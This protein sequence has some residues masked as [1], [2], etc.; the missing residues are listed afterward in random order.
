M[1]AAVVHPFREEGEYRGA[2]HIGDKVAS[3]FYIKA[4]KNSPVAQVDIDLAALSA[5][6]SKSGDC[7]CQGTGDPG[8]HFVVNP[9]GY[10]VFHVSGGAG[11][12][13]VHLRK[14]DEDPKLPI[15]DSRKL[16]EGDIYSG[17]IL[18]PGRYSVTNTL[19]ECTA[20][21]RVPYLVPGKTAYRPP[22]PVRVD[23]AEKGFQPGKI[24]AHPGQGILFHFRQASRIKIDLVEPEDR[25]EA[26]TKNV[27]A[28][29]RKIRLS[30]ESS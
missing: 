13:Y 9:K 12:F 6:A 28:G 29:W 24:E 25:P 30:D 23:V 2:V 11:G 15:F 21:L 5:P 20:E 17:V 26:A 22:A 18:R 19:S 14:A 4:D 1:L 27:R 16:G 8:S 7:C 10:A 3:V